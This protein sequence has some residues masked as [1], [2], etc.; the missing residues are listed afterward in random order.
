MLV[1][2]K[3]TGIVLA[4]TV[5]GTRYLTTGSVV[6]NNVLVLHVVGVTM[7]FDRLSYKYIEVKGQQFGKSLQ[8]VKR[9]YDS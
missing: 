2:Q 8:F 4:P 7:S 3:L 6:L 9:A 1:L 5:N